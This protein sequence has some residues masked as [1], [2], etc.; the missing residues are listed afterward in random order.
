EGDLCLLSDAVMTGYYRN[1]DATDT[2]LRR[3][4]DGKLWL[5]TG[6]IAKIAPTGDICFRSRYKRMVKVNGYNVYPMMIE[7]VMQTHPDVQE[8]C[9]IGIPWKHDTRI[10][11]YATLKR[12]ISPAEAE[13]KLIEYAAGRLNR[14]SIPV[15]VE[16]VS[17]LPRTKMD[18]TD[19]RAL[20]KMELERMNA[21]E[22]KEHKKY[23]PAGSGNFFLNNS[24]TGH[25][26]VH[27]KQ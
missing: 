15:V 8:A 27:D 21:G 13:R 19:Y 25:G 6:D 4:E 23:F 17:S 1:Q 5:H 22:S 11:L 7:E 16:I 26:Q 12:N 14:W 2:V 24:Q 3:H 9:A 10:K 18:K 20:E